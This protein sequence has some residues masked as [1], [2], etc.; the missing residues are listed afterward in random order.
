MRSNPD[1]DD[2][3]VLLIVLVAV[4]MAVV[5]LANDDAERVLFGIFLLILAGLTRMERHL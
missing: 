4:I 3:L 1:L 5:G 2:W